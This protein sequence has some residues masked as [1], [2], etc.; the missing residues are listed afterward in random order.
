MRLLLFILLGTLVF[1]FVFPAAIVFVGLVFFLLLCVVIW[2]FLIGGRAV[3]VYGNRAGQQ[4]TVNAEGREEV[5]TIHTNPDTEPSYGQREPRDPEAVNVASN[6]EE[7]DDVSEVV[8]LPATALRRD[9]ESGED[10]EE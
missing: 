10:K 2:K 3:Y 1:G 7:M 4:T 8:E 9:D 5:H 6:E